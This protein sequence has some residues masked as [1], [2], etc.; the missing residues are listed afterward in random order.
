MSEMYNTSYWAHVVFDSSAYY[1]SYAMSALP[2]LELYAIAG[3]DGI[4]AAR[5]SYIK[6]FTFSSNDDFIATD[7]FGDKYVTATYQQVLNWAG[8][9]GPFQEDLYKEIQEYFE[10]RA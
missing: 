7:S 3:N 4:D 6:L 8:L 2:C 1:I 9:K 5:D 10:S